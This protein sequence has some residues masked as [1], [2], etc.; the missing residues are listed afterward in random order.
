MLPEDKIKLFKECAHDFEKYSLR[1]KS[2]NQQL[3]AL[4]IRMENVHSPSL[5]RAGTTDPLKPHP[6]IE[7]LEFKTALEEEKQ[8]C[9]SLMQWVLDVIGQIPSRSVRVLVWMTYVQKHSLRSISEKLN[10][11]KDKLYTIRK[12]GLLAAIDDQT[13]EN[14]WSIACAVGMD[15]EPD[16]TGINGSV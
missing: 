15:P 2:L 9:L 13:V 11:N 14:Y 16:Q 1:V 8:Y 7:A 12:N 3:E 6:V 10:I 5:E 4:Q